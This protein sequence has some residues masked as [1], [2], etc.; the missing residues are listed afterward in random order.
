MLEGQ[1]S[2][3]EVAA[4]VED[5]GCGCGAKSFAVPGKNLCTVTIHHLVL[6]FAGSGTLK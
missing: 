5:A 3:L 2:S 1:Q 6:T 4:L